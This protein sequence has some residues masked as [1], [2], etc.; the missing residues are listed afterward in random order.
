M[1]RFGNIHQVA[2]GLVAYLD[3]KVS[4]NRNNTVG[5]AVDQTMQ[6]FVLDNRFLVSLKNKILQTLQFLFRGFLRQNTRNS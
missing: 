1:V 6:G 5:K 4:I 3:N 2:K